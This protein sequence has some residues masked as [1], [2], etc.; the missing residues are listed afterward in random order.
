MSE[1]RFRT[2]THDAPGNAETGGSVGLDDGGV[3]LALDNDSGE[4]PSCRYLTPSEARALA[5]A[6]NHFANEAEAGR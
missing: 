3:L 4:L 1:L 6:L 2:S 5:V